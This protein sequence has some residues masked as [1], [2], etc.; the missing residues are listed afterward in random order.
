[1]FSSGAAVQSVSADK[2]CRCVEALPT[3]TSATL[4]GG[5]SLGAGAD[6]ALDDFDEVHA[7]KHLF[8]AG[9]QRLGAEEDTGDANE[10]VLFEYLEAGNKLETRARMKHPGEVWQLAP[11]ATR[12]DLLLTIA[13]TGVERQGMLF[14]FDAD[15]G[16]L[17]E[18]ARVPTTTDHTLRKLLWHPPET[19]AAGSLG[20][21][22]FEDDHELSERF[23]AVHDGLVRLWDVEQSLT[24]M[25]DI[26]T[27]SLPSPRSLGAACW[28]PH[29]IHEVSV[30]SGDKVVGIDLRSM[31]I[32]R[33][34]DGA[35]KLGVRDLDYNPNKPYHLV[36]GGEDRR[37]KFWD[38]RKPDQP[39]KVILAHDHWVG[40][41]RYNRF[42]D[43]LVLSAG[44]DSHVSLWRLSSISSAP[45][46]G[47]DDDDDDASDVGN[48]SDDP[49]D[50]DTDAHSKGG[51]STAASTSETAD[52]LVKSYE[53][54]ADSVY[55]VAWSAAEAWVFASLS[56]D[57]KL[58]VNHVP[59]AEKY[60]IL[61]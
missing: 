8:L 11:H 52:G 49:D 58:V 21:E 31:E 29:H 10:I 40:A 46:L 48:D 28:D 61:L 56:I 35:H 39:L 60:K 55:S 47:L 16:S 9:T 50:R 41:V 17:N 34:I 4:D 51:A 5:D 22:D 2:P 36:T 3:A 59:S 1:M 23:L 25:D 42:H 24:Q 7:D 38:V 57:G 30:G 33:R 12:R 53:D 18:L 27:C 44:T 32:T 14:R 6:A 13:G 43:Q 45:L 54:H 26:G 20:G 37:V 15:A 19:S